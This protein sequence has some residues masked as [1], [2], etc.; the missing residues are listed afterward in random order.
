MK[1][2]RTG[3][4]IP[5]MTLSV[6]VFSLPTSSAERTDEFDVVM[7]A[8]IAANGQVPPGS[9]RVTAADLHSALS[10]GDLSDDPLVID[11]R[12]YPEYSAGHVPDALNIPYR[13]LG[14]ASE[15]DA[16]DSALAAHVAEGKGNEIVVYGSTHHLGMLVAAYLAATQGLPALSLRNGLA[17]WT[18]DEAAAPGRFK[19]C[20]GFDAD[21]VG[22]SPAGCTSNDFPTTTADAVDAAGVSG[23]GYPEVD[24][25]A[26]PAA[27]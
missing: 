3:L 21:G 25:I 11:L 18:A 5:L 22:I 12:T 13:E 7:A 26:G 20:T 1:W 9:V 6:L 4:S 24:C 10:N 17:E 15:L 27:P 8:A 16:L 14:R 19:E 2:T 23:G